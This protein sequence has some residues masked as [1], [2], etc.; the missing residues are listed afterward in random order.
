MGGGRRGRGVRAIAVHGDEQALQ[1]GAVLADAKLAYLTLGTLS[2][3]RDNAILLPTYYT[4]SHRQCAQM[5]GPGRALDPERWFV[6]IP[7]MLGN[8]VSSSPS[9]TPPPQG[10]AEFP[11]VTIH[12]NVRLQHRL[13][14]EHLGGLG[15]HRRAGPPAPRGRLAHER[16]HS[17][18]EPGEDRLQVIPGEGQ[19]PIAR[20]PPGDLL[21]LRAPGRHVTAC[22]VTWS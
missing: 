2:P 5:V 14:T 17:L 12:D 10:G 22:R 20:V 11:R 21:E 15:P 7:N 16:G 18:G 19:C 9:N 13:L 1:C 3:A 8:A 6:I 4:G